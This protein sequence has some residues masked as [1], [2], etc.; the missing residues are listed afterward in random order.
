MKAI[1]NRRDFNPQEIVK[2]TKI[3]YNKILLASI[4]DLIDSIY[5]QASDNNIV[6]VNKKEDS[7]GALVSDEEKRIRFRINKFNLEQMTMKVIKPSMRCLF[8]SKERF[9]KKTN[10]IRIATIDITR[11][12]SHVYFF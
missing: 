10:M 11:W 12:L 9:L 4:N 8:Q 6:N 3:T 2:R 5:G 7:C 1:C